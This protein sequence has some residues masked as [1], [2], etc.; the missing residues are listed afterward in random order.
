MN[1]EQR[2]RFKEVGKVAFIR[3]EMTRL[4]YWPPSPEV[5]AKSAEAEAVLRP[6]YEELAILRTELT[7]IEKEIALTGD[8]PNLLA[9]VRR[10]RIERVRAARVV[11]KAAREKEQGERKASDI[12]WRRSTLPFLGHGVSAG[13]RYAGGDPAKLAAS[14]LPVLITAGDLATAIGIGTRDLAFLT[15][16]RG[17][18]MLDHYSRFTIPK[19]RGGVRV[20]SSPK[21]R[22]RV[23]QQYVLEKVLA[24]LPVHDAAAAFRPG[25]SIVDNAAKHAGKPI[26]IRIDLKDFFPS[27]PFGRVKQLFESFGYNPG[28]A[29][30]FGLLC[31]EAPRAAVTLDGSAKRFVAVGE[32]CLP[33]GACTSPTLTNLLCRRLD[34]RLSGLADAGGFTYTRYADDLVFSHAE[35]GAAVGALLRAVRQIITETGFVINEEKIVVLRPHHRQSVTGL[36]TNGGTPRVSRQDL[37]RFRAF[38]HQF[39]A[40]G[41]EAMTQ[42]IGKDALCYA[43]G[44]LSFIHMVSPEQAE[45]IAAKHP[46]LLRWKKG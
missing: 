18:A 34:A 43:A 10:K 20:I 23:A 13:L 11:K 39:D 2:A 46:W 12:A 22:L 41:A 28:V 42:Q 15:Y 45:K 3:E 25:L 29:T 31:T 35:A 9:E 44:Y 30:L 4:G 7:G 8:I 6:M 24:L 14:G 5:A 33:Q 17:V 21:R 27:V 1:A 36:V 38:L 40:K 26:V 19:K 37:R 32:R 16:H